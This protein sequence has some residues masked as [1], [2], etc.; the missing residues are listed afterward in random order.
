MRQEERDFGELKSVQ[1]PERT[2]VAKT[3]YALTFVL[4][5]V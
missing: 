4:L 1:H 5:T 3:S 2:M